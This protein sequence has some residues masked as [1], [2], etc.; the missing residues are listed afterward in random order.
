MEMGYNAN[1]AINCQLLPYCCAS[2]PS[3]TAAVETLVAEHHANKPFTLI[4]LDLPA[5]LITQLI[6]VVLAPILEEPMWCSICQANEAYKLIALIWL[7]T[8]HY[9]NLSFSLLQTAS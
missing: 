3:H 9:A 2:P 7:Q 5:I 6:I 4:I 1:N 8:V